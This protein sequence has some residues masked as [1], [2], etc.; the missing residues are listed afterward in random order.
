MSNVSSYLSSNSFNS[1]IILIKILIILFVSFFLISNFNPYFEGNDSYSYAVIAKQLSQGNLFYTNDFLSTGELEFIPHDVMITKD[2]THALPAGYAGFFGITTASYIVAGNYGLFYLGPILGIIFLIVCERISTNLFGKYVGL[3]TL[4][5]LSTNHLFFRSSLNLQTESIFSIFFIIGC[6]FLIRFFQTNNNKYILGCSTFLVISTL[7]RINGVIYF[8]IELGLLFSFIIF[9]KIQHKITQNKFNSLSTISKKFSSLNRNDIFKIIFFVTIPWLIF[10]IFYFSYFGYFFDDPFTNHVVVSHGYETTDV[11][12]S[13]LLL[14]DSSK[15][16]NIKEYSKY[17]LPY[18]FPRIIDTTNIFSQIDDL[19][20]ENWLGMLALLLLGFFSFFSL[21]NKSHRLTII[22]FSMMIV[23]TIWFFSA[24]TNEERALRGDL[25]GRYMFPAFSLYYM[26]LGFL[27]VKFLKTS[28]L[29]K[30]MNV[31]ILTGLKI[32]SIFI[33]VLFF[34]SAFYFSPPIQSIFENDFDLK[35]P[36]KFNDKYPLEKEGLSSNSI[37]ISANI[38]A[39]DYGF[40]QFK[41]YLD[42]DNISENSIILLKKTIDDGNDVYLMKSP[43]DKK[44]KIIYKN[45][46]NLDE[47]VITDHSESFCKLE[48]S[49]FSKKMINNMCEI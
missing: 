28:N 17:L 36:T 44:D 20:G 15:F 35:D 5:F 9:S 1:I 12:S 14:L 6:Y 37:L 41:A 3:L 24:V 27:I 38:D 47:F 22:T 21:F 26:M 33:L 2:G 11:K 48:L 19:L 31:K 40:I 10:F 42:G 39:M 34:S 8:P 43:F 30:I 46:A 25:P 4:L 16:D 32:T 13:S 49:K 23:G 18:Q 7:M 45:L 29:K